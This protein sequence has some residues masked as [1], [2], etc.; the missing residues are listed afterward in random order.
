LVKIK[1]GTRRSSR[2]NVLSPEQLE[3]LLDHIQEDH[4][5]LIVVTAICLGLRFSEVLALKWMDIDWDALTI[6]VRRAIVPGRVDE[7][8]TEYSEAPVPLDSS[9][10]ESLLEWRRKILERRRL[11][12]RFAV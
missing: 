2:P 6:Y 5:R 8:K 7:T 10:I 3:L 4:V 9:L 11:D 1:G 12:F